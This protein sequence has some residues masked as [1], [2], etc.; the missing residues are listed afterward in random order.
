MSLGP[1]SEEEE[2]V[3]QRKRGPVINVKKTSY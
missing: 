3:I 2:F 1:E